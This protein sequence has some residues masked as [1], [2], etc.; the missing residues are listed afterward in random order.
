MKLKVQYGPIDFYGCC[1]MAQYSSEV[2]WSLNT[3]LCMSSNAVD[4]TLPLQVHESQ[5]LLV[6]IHMVQTPDVHRYE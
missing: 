5:D 1:I 4:P 2:V 3:P 6:P